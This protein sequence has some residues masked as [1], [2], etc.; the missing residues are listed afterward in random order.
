MGKEVCGRPAAE[1]LSQSLTLARSALRA[2]FLRLICSFIPDPSHVQQR[3]TVFSGH[4][5]SHLPAF[6]G[7]LPV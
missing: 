4:F 6:F 7:V 2:F 5:V 1:K 3:L